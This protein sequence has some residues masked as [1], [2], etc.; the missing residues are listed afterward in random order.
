MTGFIKAL[1]LVPVGFIVI[2]LAI[3]NR[4]PVTISFDPFSA[5]SDPLFA[6][7]TPLWL[8]LLCT[9]AIGVLIGGCAAW[10]A[11]G[12]HRKLERQYKR[13][14]DQLRREVEAARAAPPALTTG[15][16]VRG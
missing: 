3:A 5:A 14:A 11:Q 8:A 4:A 16:G 10:L 12:R 2:L 13:E 1:I 6:L 7:T 9:L 15:D